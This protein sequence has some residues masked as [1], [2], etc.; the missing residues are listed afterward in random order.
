MAIKKSTLEQKWYYRLAKVFF[1]ILPFLI[2]ILFILRKR[3]VVCSSLI[4]ENFFDLSPNYIIFIA[5]ALIL[6]F[7]F[8]K[9]IWRGFLY[10]VFGG[11]EDDKKDSS[12]AI[13]QSVNSNIKSTSVR[14]GGLLLLLIV[15]I[16]L[17]LI[18]YFNINRPKQFNTF[19]QSLP[20]I[21]GESSSGGGGSKIT[22]PTKSN[23]PCNSVKNGIGT[24]GV[25]VPGNC[26]CPSDTDYVQ[27]D[28]ITKGGPY[29]ICKCK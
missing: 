22:C 23:P 19:I 18:T 20:S 16:V 12:G 27:M 25:I 1:L 21:N 9:W 7:L 29:K 3:I 14:N 4:Q 15:I 6:Y 26:N 10:I 8:L 28:N 24:S 5:V 2:A 13:S 11:S 17:L